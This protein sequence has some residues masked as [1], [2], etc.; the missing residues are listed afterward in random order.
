MQTGFA[1]RGRLAGLFMFQNAFCEVPREPAAFRGKRL[2]SFE[3]MLDLNRRK[4]PARCPTSLGDFC[5]P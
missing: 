2:R 1:R 5:Y 4:T 3:H